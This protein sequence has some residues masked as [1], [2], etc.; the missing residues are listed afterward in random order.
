MW[1]LVGKSASKAVSHRLMLSDLSEIRAY[2]TCEAPR[3]ER[4]GMCTG[5]LQD[6]CLMWTESTGGSV[7]RMGG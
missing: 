7:G 4:R 1:L 2:V 5:K 3:Q 6:P